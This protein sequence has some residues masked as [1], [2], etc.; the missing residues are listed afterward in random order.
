VWGF[1][2]AIEFRD[3]EHV[4]YDIFL[5]NLFTHT[6]ADKS[7]GSAGVKFALMVNTFVT[8]Q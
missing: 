3:K 5:K 1:R 6:P 2:V 8:V 4:V 7:L